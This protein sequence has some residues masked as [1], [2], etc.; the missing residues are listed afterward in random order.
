MSIYI[1]LSFIRNVLSCN[2]YNDDLEKLLISIQM[3]VSYQEHPQY[4]FMYEMINLANE[5][6]KNKNYILAS[7]DLGLIHNFPKDDISK[8]NEK[9]FYSAEFLDYCDN[10]GELNKIKKIK[11]VMRL[12]STYLIVIP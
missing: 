1:E 6:I 3:E 7:Y 5:E 12:I 9:Y 10:L 8:W 11:I 2:K 4:K